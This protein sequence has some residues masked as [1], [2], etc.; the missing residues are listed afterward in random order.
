MV[1]HVSIILC[2]RPYRFSTAFRN[3]FGSVSTALT[4]FARLYFLLFCFLWLATEVK[5]PRRL[6]QQAT[7]RGKYRSMATDMV[8]TQTQRTTAALWRRLIRR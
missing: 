4:G 5:Q 8:V 3:Y 1:R 2:N 6:R 7:T